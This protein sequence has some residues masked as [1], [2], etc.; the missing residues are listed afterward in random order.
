VGAVEIS[1][2]A[3]LMSRV[4]NWSINPIIK[5]PV[6][7]HTYYVTIRLLSKSGTKVMKQCNLI[8]LL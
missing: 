2:G 5:N 4:Y 3:V 8:T 6:Y 7:S 1:G